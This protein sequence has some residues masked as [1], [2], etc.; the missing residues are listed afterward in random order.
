MERNHPGLDNGESSPRV[1][2]ADLGLGSAS[3][4]VVNPE[5]LRELERVAKAL[6]D[7]WSADTS[8]SP[9]EWSPDN[10]VLGQCA[11]TACVFQD[12]FGGDILNSQVTLPDGRV[13]SHYYNLLGGEE[14]DLTRQQFPLG[15]VFTPGRPKTGDF[16]TTRDYCL[17]YE[18]TRERY[19]RLKA[20]VK[21]ML[22]D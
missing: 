15:S 8:A 18:A 22:G 5:A 10:P 9:D 21:E 12:Y 11:V 3:E 20:K 1:T 7:A 19:D 17:S 2:R 14:E 16:A 4:V 13:D 6:S